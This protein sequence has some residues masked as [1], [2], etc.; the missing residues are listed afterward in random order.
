LPDRRDDVRPS[1]ARSP[2]SSL[3]ICEASAQKGHVVQYGSP[4]GRESR[5][6]D[7]PGRGSDESRF[8]WLWPRR[9]SPSKR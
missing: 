1:R 3:R 5:L 6:G 2:T 7:G 8:A 4:L 9:L